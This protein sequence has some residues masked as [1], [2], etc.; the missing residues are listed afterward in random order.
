MQTKHDSLTRRERRELE[1]YLSPWG[2]VF[3][4]ALFVAPIT[5][6][7]FMSWRIQV[8]VSQHGLWWLAPPALFGIVL[9]YFGRRWTGGKEYV[10]QIRA[11]LAANSVEVLIVNVVDAIEV[12]EMEDEGPTYFL[13][14]DDG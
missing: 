3:R 1:N 9:Y 2:G 10:E 6:V 8:A 11:D 7:A 4:I 12:E 13:K 5:F 14:T